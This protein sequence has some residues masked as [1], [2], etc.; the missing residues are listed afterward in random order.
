MSEYRVS[1]GYVAFFE[2]ANNKWEEEHLCDVKIVKAKSALE[3]SE[4][5]Y[6]QQKSIP[7][8]HVL[9]VEEIIKRKVDGTLRRKA[10]SQ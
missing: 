2:D 4:L 8:L 10:S 5:A 6:K 3:A 9:H 7:Y 1:L